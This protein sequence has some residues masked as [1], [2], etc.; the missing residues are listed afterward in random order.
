MPHVSKLNISRRHQLLPQPSPAVPLWASSSLP[1][2][3][4]SISK[5]LV[6]CHHHRHHPTPSCRCLSQRWLECQLK[7]TDLPPT[8]SKMEFKLGPCLQPLHSH[9]R[10]LLCSWRSTY[11]GILSV[12]DRVKVFSSLRLLL[13]R[14]L[15]YD[16]SFPSSHHS[17]N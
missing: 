11:I 7:A 3:W 6:P 4:N 14:L 12:A 8:A 2:L 13:H 10:S 1:H 15:Y 16:C 5:L 17:S 9:C